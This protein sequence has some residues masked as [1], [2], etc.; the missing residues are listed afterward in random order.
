[1]AG[2]LL[3]DQRNSNVEVYSWNFFD[4]SARGTVGAIVDSAEPTGSRATASICEKL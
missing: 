4:V 3:H 2:S 1:M